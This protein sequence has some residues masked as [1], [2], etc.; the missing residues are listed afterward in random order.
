MADPEEKKQPIDLNKILLPKKEVPGSTTQSAAR[1]NA[2]AL[3]AQEQQATLQPV[4]KPPTEAEVAQQKMQSK[5]VSQEETIVKPL[6]TF[7]GDIERVVQQK[8][9]SVVSMAADEAKRREQQPLT[10][11]VPK[12]ITLAGIRKVAMIALGVVLLASAGGLGAYLFITTLPTIIP[13]EPQTPHMHV[14]LSETVE[15]QNTSRSMM[16]QFVTA[17]D[18]LTPPLGLMVRLDARVASTSG[19]TREL[20]TAEFMDA[21]GVRVPEELTRTLD[22]QF[23][24]GLYAYDGNSPFL[25]LKTDSYERAFAGMLKWEISMRDDLLPLFDKKIQYR[26]P[27]P[28]LPIATSTAS[29]SVPVIPQAP[30]LIPFIDK[31]V[32]NHD[33]RILENEFRDQLL[34]WTFLDRN[35][36]LITTQEAAVAEVVKR[37]KN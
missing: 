37:L 30:I 7:Q 23:I 9:V 8:N 36:I 28:P 2:G 17:R 20:T 13:P 31:I 34:L 21:L 33:A 16:Q 14:D 35:T 29:S 6:Q 5:Q 3:L 22:P 1:V 18:T 12:K 4:E 11:E 10:A 27:P 32:S 24:L 19:E 26:L 15:L 25:L